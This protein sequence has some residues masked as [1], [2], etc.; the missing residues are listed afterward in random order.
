MYVS[1]VLPLLG[2]LLGWLLSYRRER[3]SLGRQQVQKVKE[4]VTYIAGD[5]Q[6]YRIQSQLNNCAHQVDLCGKVP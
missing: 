3:E 4:Q 2:P 1:R 5:R 6:I